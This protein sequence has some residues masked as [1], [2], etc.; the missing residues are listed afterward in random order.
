M[1]NILFGTKY[2]DLVY[3]FHAFRREVLEIIDIK[4]GS[5]AIDTELYLKA[6]KAGLKVEEV[7]S[8]E[9][10]RIYGSG[11][12]RSLSDGWKILKLILKERFHG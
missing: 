9:S 2:T 8:F 10:R 3:G 1:V 5:F 6:K 7:P 12:L 11:K 4:S